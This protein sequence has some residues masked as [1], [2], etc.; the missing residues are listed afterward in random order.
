MVTQDNKPIDLSDFKIGKVK[1]EA[2]IFDKSPKVLSLGVQDKKGLRD[3]LNV[4]GGIRVYRDGIR[5][6]DY[7]EPENDWLSLDIRRVN[8]PGKK[9]SNNI[10]IGAINLKRD[11]SLDLIEKTN[12]EGFIENQAYETFVAAILYALDKVETLRKIDKDKLR[13]FYGPTAAT[14]PVIA[15]LN[16]LSDLIDKKMEEGSLKKEVNKYLKRIEDDYKYINEILLRSAGAGLSLG[17]VIHEIE[18]IIGEMKIVVEKEQL[19]ERIVSLVK[20]LSHLV[21]GYS[22][23]VRNTGKKT[24]DLKKIIE[25][26]LFNVEFR[27][28]THKI[29]IISGYNGFKGDSKVNCARNLIIG[30]ILNI[31]DNSIWW[32]DYGNVKNKKIYITISNELPEHTCILIADNGPGFSLPVE[33]ITKPFVSGKPD[34]MGLGLHIANEIMEAHKGSLLFPDEDD[35]TIPKKFEKGAIVALAFRKQE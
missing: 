21:E 19:S 15:N 23:L 30:T 20:H 8:V 25:Q 27:L 1:F 28:E 22:V 2:L 31:I 10:V 26:A 35:F 24:E 33:E 9:L 5:V 4:N 11:E 3:Y 16:E 34:G 14:E 17:V 18:K 6:Y 29:E 32:F 13:I 12:R 7:G